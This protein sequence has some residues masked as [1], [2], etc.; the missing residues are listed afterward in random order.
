MTTKCHQRLLPIYRPSVISRDAAT[1]RLNTQRRLLHIDRR[2]VTTS[3]G[4]VLR[5]PYRDY[6]G[7]SSPVLNVTRVCGPFTGQKCL[8]RPSAISV[9]CP[10]YRPSV[11]YH[12]VPIND[13]CP[14]TEQAS[15]FVIL[16]RDGLAPNDDCYTFIDEVSH[17][18]K[19]TSYDIHIATTTILLPAT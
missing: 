11:I 16:Q 10:I 14:F 6:Y 2:S 9:C 5:H 17:L 7:T 15:S 4:N 8:P 3:N 19:G 1:R 13:C 12:T 18:L